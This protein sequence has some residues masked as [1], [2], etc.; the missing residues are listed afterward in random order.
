VKNKKEPIISAEI[1]TVE[2][3]CGMGVAHDF[4]SDEALPYYREELSKAKN[5]GG[6]GFICAGFREGDDL[7]EGVF[8]LMEDRGPCVFR[9][10]TKLNKNSG[11]RF[12]F[13]VFDWSNDPEYGF[14]DGDDD[15]A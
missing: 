8:A 7:D 14:D 4:R 6:T 9:T 15:D 5:D 3:A 2:G 13:A 12:Y 10:E 1:H 11:N